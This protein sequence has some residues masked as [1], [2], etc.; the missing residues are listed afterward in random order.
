[1]A[2]LQLNN[3]YGY[4]GRKQINIQTDNIKNDNLN[5]YILSRIVK[6]IT[7]I[8]DNYSTILSY[9]NI[10]HKMLE[11]LN[12]EL[13]SDIKGYQSLIKSNV[14]IAAAVTSY[15]RVVM[16][17]FKIDPNTL[18]TD[19]DSIFITKP[20]DSLLKMESDCYSIYYYRKY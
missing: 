6:S 12:N 8:N 11:Q 17:P 3:L 9:T 13:H 10:N 16:I 4:F 14:A 5:L 7:P 2:K 1:M 18:C 15:A 20:I 19:T